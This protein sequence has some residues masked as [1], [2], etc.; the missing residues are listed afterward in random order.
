MTK[1]KQKTLLEIV[2]KTYLFADI[3]KTAKIPFNLVKIQNSSG[4]ITATCSNLGVIANFS[5][6]SGSTDEFAF[7][8]N[9]QRLFEIVKNWTMSEEIDF[10]ISDGKVVLKA[11]SKRVTLPIIDEEDYWPGRGPKPESGFVMPFAQFKKCVESS[12]FCSSPSAHDVAQR[13]ILIESTADGKLVLATQEGVRLV[14]LVAEDIHVSG[15]FRVLVDAAMLRT[16]MRVFDASEDIHV[17]VTDARVDLLTTRSWVGISTVPA[18]YPDIMRV[19]A[20]RY[21]NT[22]DISSDSLKVIAKSILSVI[23][24]TEKP[25][26]AKV[27]IT[28]DSLCFYAVTESGDIEDSIPIVAGN[29]ETM[30]EMK[31]CDIVYFSE[32][33]DYFKELTL[34]TSSDKRH[35]Y[36]FTTKELPGWIYQLVATR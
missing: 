10:Q 33:A 3:T 19:R 29:G 27:T 2:T 36:V 4:E 34:E 30:D 35:G 31:G 13:C 9:A 28:S 20:M 12:S 24:N 1:I 21:P 15:S 7:T 16:A 11:K 22:Y 25:R 17:G 14:S 5:A 26:N 18:K 23:R 8:V 6:D 32:A